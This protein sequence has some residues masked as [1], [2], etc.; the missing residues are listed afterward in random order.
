MLWWSVLIFG[1][2]L[3]VT[4]CIQLLPMVP[5]IQFRTLQRK[6]DGLEELTEWPWLSVIVPAR[7]EGPHIL[8]GLKSLLASDYPHLE[9]IAVDDRSRD[10]TGR[11]MDELAAADSRLKVIHITELPE[12][13][14]GKNHA[15]HIGQQ[16]ARGEW[17][18]FTDGDVLFTSDALRRSLQ[19]MLHE[20]LDFLSLFPRMIPGGY[21]ENALI[22]F[23]SMAFMAGTRPY[24][25]RSKNRAAYV[26]IGAFNMV[27]R[28]AYTA[29]GGHIPLRLEILDDVRLGQLFKDH[30]FACDIL[31]AGPFVSVRWQHSLWGAIRGLEKNGFAALGF[32]VG[33]MALVTVMLLTG[34]FLPYVVPFIYPDIRATGYI[35]T[36]VLMHAVFGFLGVRM[37]NSAWLW[38]AYPVAVLLTQ[39]AFL[40]STWVTLQQGGVRWR[41]T[42]YPMQLLKANKYRS[43]PPQVL[44]TQELRAGQ[45]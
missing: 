10:D 25:V 14:L 32:S 39:F 21:W 43:Q 19:F 35:A 8:A 18:L 26:G 1:W 29:C 38:P 31:V 34:V 23:F 20:R 13:W 33:R 7:D 24:L 9:V 3:F 6:T 28:S 15:M 41:D 42:F 45:S 12:G 22:T 40:R 44:E 37:A 17:L 11:V 4:W 27:R 16:A 36:L 2:V 5:S 30:D